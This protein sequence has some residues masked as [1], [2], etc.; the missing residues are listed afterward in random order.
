MLK[1]RSFHT[2][3]R[4][5]DWNSVLILTNCMVKPP[6][7]RTVTRNY[8]PWEFVVMNQLL[9]NMQWC[10]LMSN[11]EG[12]RHEL[13]MR[14]FPVT[15]VKGT[16]WTFLTNHNLVVLLDKHKFAWQEIWCIF[17]IKCHFR[18]LNKSLNFAQ[19]VS[20]YIC[21]C[22]KSLNSTDIRYGLRESSPDGMYILKYGSFILIAYGFQFITR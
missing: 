12:H 17:V 11:N 7:R 1:M 5:Y 3:F 15:E 14:W 20:V 22:S 19:L 21:K 16:W 6:Y 10:R 2:L 13:Y 8:L 18:L 9:W 4:L